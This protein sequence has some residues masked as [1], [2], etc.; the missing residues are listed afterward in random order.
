MFDA[1]PRCLRP[2]DAHCSFLRA[3]LARVIGEVG[4]FKILGAIVLLVLVLVVNQLVRQQ[5]PTEFG[6]HHESMFENVPFVPHRVRMVRGVNEY[7]ALSIE[8]PTAAPS[9]TFAP[10]LMGTV[11]DPVRIRVARKMALAAY[12]LRFQ[13]HDPRWLAA[14]TLT[15]AGRNLVW[16]RN[17]AM[18][19][20]EYNLNYFDGV[21]Q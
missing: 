13:R 20:H 9:M 1:T 21:C 2:N 18:S 17:V 11:A 15:N 6:L 7:I 14:T 3:M 19:T 10:S 16:R 8:H 4:Q 5:A 12:C